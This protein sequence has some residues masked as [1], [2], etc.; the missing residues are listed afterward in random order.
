MRGARR[1]PALAGGARGWAVVAVA[2]GGD[3]DALGAG[4]AVAAGCGAD[5]DRARRGCPV[6][7]RQKDWTIAIPAALRVNDG[8]VAA[9]AR[10]LGVANT[11]IVDRVAR[12]PSLWPVGVAR[13]GIGRPRL[14][15]DGAVTAALI[16]SGGNQSH[17][18]ELLGVGR[19]TI[20]ER[21]A[22][23]P[24]VWPAGVARIAQGRHAGGAR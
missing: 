22:L 23:R 14:V 17:A 11:S 15:E 9:A 24:E 18:A 16:L 10:M 5:A 2:P 6:S 1:R 21:L 3:V 4:D 8:N 13:R 7:A 19:T 12:K 20:C